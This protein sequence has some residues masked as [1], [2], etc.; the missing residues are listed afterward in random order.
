MIC[1]YTVR[2]MCSVT[3]DFV[4]DANFIGDVMI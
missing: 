1:R 2:F 3:L 4:A